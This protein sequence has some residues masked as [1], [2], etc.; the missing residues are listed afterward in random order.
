[1][2]LQNWQRSSSRKKLTILTMSLA[3]ASTVSSPF[4][5]R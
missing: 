2:M 5:I 3:S 1:M 4:A